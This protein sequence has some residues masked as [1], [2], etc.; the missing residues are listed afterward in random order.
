MITFVYMFVVNNLMSIPWTQG[1]NQKHDEYSNNWYGVMVFTQAKALIIS[2]VLYR[3]WYYA[4]N[5][6]FVN[7]VNIENKKAKQEK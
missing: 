5:E 2:C 1:L 6:S 7:F 4:I 3:Y